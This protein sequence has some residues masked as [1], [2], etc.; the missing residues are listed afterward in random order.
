MVIEGP[1]H[2]DITI[3]LALLT[4]NFSNFSN[5]KMPLRFT[6]CHHFCHLFRFGNGSGFYFLPLLLFCLLLGTINSDII[7]SYIIKRIDD[8]HVGFEYMLSTLFFTN[9][10]L[11]SRNVSFYGD[12]KIILPY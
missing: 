7:H 1:T 5:T 10:E 2:S 8:I 9:C 3:L 11:A 4:F 6:I 12:P